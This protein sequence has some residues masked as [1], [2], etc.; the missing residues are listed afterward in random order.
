MSVLKYNE[1]DIPGVWGCFRSV[2]S[3]LNSSLF[4]KGRNDKKNAQL[5][6]AGEWNCCSK[7]PLKSPFT[8]AVSGRRDEQGRGG[9]GGEV[10][11]LRG[12]E[13]EVEKQG[14][15]LCKGL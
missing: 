15:Q 4:T 3:M 12:E 13:W 7:T 9:G 5:P 14:L 2:L 10:G 6:T 8:A 11:V 1:V